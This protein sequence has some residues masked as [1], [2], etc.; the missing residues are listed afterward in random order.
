ML[1]EVETKRVLVYAMGG[2]TATLREVVRRVQL[3]Q[4]FNELPALTA[5]DVA[6]TYGWSI[7]VSI[8][9]TTKLLHALTVDDSQSWAQNGV[10][11]TW[12]GGVKFLMSLKNRQLSTTKPSL[13]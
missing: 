10:M 12:N 4:S 1:P 7:D 11:S 13:A 3:G 6:M 9:V 8:A 2:K 5:Y